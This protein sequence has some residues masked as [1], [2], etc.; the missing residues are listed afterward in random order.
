MEAGW[1][2]EGSKKKKKPSLVHVVISRRL[3]ASCLVSPY[4]PCTQHTT[5]EHAAVLAYRVVVGCCTSYSR[6]SSTF[7]FS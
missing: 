6:S 1:G 5:S 4:C 3:A 7:K 2:E